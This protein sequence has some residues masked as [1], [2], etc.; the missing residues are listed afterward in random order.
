MASIHIAKKALESAAER[1]G[2][3]YSGADQDSP[4]RAIASVERLTLDR[5]QTP[6]GEALLAFDHEGYLRAFDWDDHEERMQRILRRHYG[7]GVRL[8]AGTAPEAIRRRIHRYFAGDLAQLD[9]IEC[10]T[11]G[12]DFQRRVWAALRRIPAGQTLGYGA[13]AATLGVPNA[14]RAVGL[15]NGA[16]PIGVVVPCHRVI[17]ADGSLTGYGGGLDRKRWLLAHEGAI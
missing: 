10:R 4:V 6:I 3:G 13:L 2:R 11:A 7:A 8:D 1:G 15:A 9:G 12:T 17:G 16:N 5:L 14:S